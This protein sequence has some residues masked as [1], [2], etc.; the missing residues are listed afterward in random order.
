MERCNF[1]AVEEN[2]TVTPLDLRAFYGGAARM[3]Q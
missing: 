3:W 1:A 2:A